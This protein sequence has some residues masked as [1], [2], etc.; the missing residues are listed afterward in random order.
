[1]RVVRSVCGT[2][3]G[4]FAVLCL[5]LAGKHVADPE[6][7]GHPEG[8]SLAMRVAIDVLLAG[9]SAFTG[10]SIFPKSHTKD[11]IRSVCGSVLGLFALV[12]L[13]VLWKH[14]AHPETIVDPERVSLGTRVVIDA[15]LAAASAFAAYS[16]FT[17]DRSP[18]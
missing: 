2:V 12:P 6:T 13:Y 8:A 5:C 14:V 11:I 3:L 16:M 4:L 18:H 10:Y 9:M 1:M 15:I 17:W 7:I